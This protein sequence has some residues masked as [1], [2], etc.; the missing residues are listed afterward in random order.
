[1]KAKLGKSVELFEFVLFALRL[2]PHFFLCFLW[3]LSLSDTERGK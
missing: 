3:C 1:M 2:P